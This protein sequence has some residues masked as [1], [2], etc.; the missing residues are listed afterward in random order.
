M[1]R[2][3]IRRAGR[4]AQLAY[5][6]IDG[7]EDSRSGSGIASAQLFELAAARIGLLLHEVQIFEALAPSGGDDNQQTNR[8]QQAAAQ[9]GITESVGW[10]IA[11]L[12]D[13]A[14]W[15]SERSR[16]LPSRAESYQCSAMISAAVGPPGQQRQE[17][18]VTLAELPSPGSMWE[19]SM[20][21]RVAQMTTPDLVVSGGATMPHDLAHPLRM[22]TKD[23]CTG[24]LINI[25]WFAI[26]ALQSS[27]SLPPCQAL[28][29]EFICRCAML[30]PSCE[31]WGAAGPAQGEM[32]TLSRTYVFFAAKAME[33]VPYEVWRQRS[34]YDMEAMVPIEAP[35]KTWLAEFFRD[36][37]YK[38]LVDDDVKVRRLQKAAHLTSCLLICSAFPFLIPHFSPPYPTLQGPVTGGQHTSMRRVHGSVNVAQ[39]AAHRADRH[40]LEYGACPFCFRSDCGQRGQCCQ[41]EAA[42]SRSRSR[43]DGSAWF[44][45]QASGGGCRGG[46]LRGPGW[47]QEA[48]E[49]GV[50]IQ[51]RR[52][53][54]QRRGFSDG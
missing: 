14:E 2:R 41:A 42:K 10:G 6:A 52:E 47:Q 39:G 27:P 31:L 49:M 18:L 51:R 28:H 43:R 32:E 15:Q 50:R 44:R 53:F 16:I 24:M 20:C 22:H 45:S 54:A 3:A 8:H 19:T 48:A 34:H 7:G 23:T 35:T 36:H 4:N 26:P 25:E 33:L 30:L 11:H 17:T 1:L 9:R 40:A 13:R 38:G 12:L 46:A 37:F 5:S 29:K 21:R